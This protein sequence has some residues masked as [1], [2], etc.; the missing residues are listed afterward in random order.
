MALAQLDL[1]VEMLATEN[2]AVSPSEAIHEVR[3]ALKRL[4]ALL[5]LVSDQLG[6]EAVARDR[7][8]LRRVAR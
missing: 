3:K 8:V 6:E 5:S 7:A 1:A 2:G 4:R